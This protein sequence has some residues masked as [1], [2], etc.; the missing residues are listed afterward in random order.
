MTRVL[1]LAVFVSILGGCSKA[2]QVVPTELDV[3]A[4]QAAIKDALRYLGEGSKLKAICGPSVGKTLFVDADGA[5]FEPD[6][7][8]DGV[9]ALGFSAGGKP[10]VVHRDALKEMVRVTED[11]GVVSFLAHPTD[12][13]LGS[14][15]ITFP[16]TGIVET[17]SLVRSAEG[18]LL[19]LWTST[20]S[21]GLAPPRSLAFLSKCEAL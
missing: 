4:E 19:D 12:P 3:M 5:K 15:I 9:I 13:D 20:R 21:N 8:S 14:W 1:A 2:E 6:Q 10:D 18:K 17:H 7:I 16:S 11:E